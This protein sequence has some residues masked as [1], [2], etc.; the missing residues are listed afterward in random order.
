MGIPCAVLIGD[1][2]EAHAWNLLYL[3][4]DYYVMDVTW[5]DPIGNPANTYYYNYFNITD[6]EISKD[7]TRG[8]RGDDLNIS[9]NLP[10]ANGTAYNFQN[11]YNGSAYG[12]NFDGINGEL[13]EQIEYEDYDGYEGDDQDDYQGDYEDYDDDGNQDYY[14]YSDYGEDSGWWNTLDSSWTQDD[15]TYD[16]EGYWYIYDEDTGYYYLYVE[17][18][19]NFGAMTEDQETIYWLDNETGEWIEQ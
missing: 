15:W 3:D 18:D 10:M 7:H 16:E 14:E 4:G 6:G 13:P 8:G 19:E 2:G 5:D 12:T 1:A 11:Y 9:L 17:E